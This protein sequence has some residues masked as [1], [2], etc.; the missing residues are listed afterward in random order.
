MTEKEQ[1][2]LIKNYGILIGYLKGLRR[3]AD[4]QGWSAT[5]NDICRQLDELG[6]NK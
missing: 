4:A 1:L 2:Q 3:L 5:Y 6:E